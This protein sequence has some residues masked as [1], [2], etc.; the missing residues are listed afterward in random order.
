MRPTAIP[1][2]PD[3][4]FI[5]SRRSAR[6]LRRM[7]DLALSF[8]NRQNGSPYDAQSLELSASIY[9][10]VLGHDEQFDRG[11]KRARFAVLRLTKT[12]AVLIEGGFLTERGERPPHREQR[13]A[14]QTRAI[15]L[16]R[17]R[18]LS[19][20]RRHEKAADGRRRLSPHQFG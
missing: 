17:H 4:K 18:R 3:L 2:R 13:L 9:H 1:L 11:I 16:H 19:R 10:S 6:R 7:T 14:R 5:R 20:S 8:I 15:D 12:P